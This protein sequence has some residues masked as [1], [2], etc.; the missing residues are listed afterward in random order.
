M[1]GVAQVGGALG[2]VGTGGRSSPGRVGHSLV[3]GDEKGRGNAQS[4]AKGRAAERCGLIG[5]WVGRT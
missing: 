5:A 2:V 1:C 4:G 3:P